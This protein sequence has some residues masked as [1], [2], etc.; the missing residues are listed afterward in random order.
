MLKYLTK[1]MVC[2]SVLFVISGTF[3]REILDFSQK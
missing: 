3:L 2:M 1:P